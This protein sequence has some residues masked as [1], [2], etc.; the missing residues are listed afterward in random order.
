MTGSGVIVGT[1]VGS[2]GMGV[3]VL[4][5]V[6]YSRQSILTRKSNLRISPPNICAIIHKFIWNALLELVI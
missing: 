6:K 1:V 3:E 4:Q 5:P 2:A